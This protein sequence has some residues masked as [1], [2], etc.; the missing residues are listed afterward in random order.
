MRDTRAM[1]GSSAAIQ[2]HLAAAEDR[3]GAALRGCCSAA[4]PPP[5]AAESLRGDA[6]GKMLLCL[7]PQAQHSR[8]FR[9]GAAGGCCSVARRPPPPLA[10]LSPECPGV[11]AAGA[12]CCGWCP[13]PES[14]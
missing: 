8:Q 1:A 6:A 3:L 10:Q 13:L 9:T 4:R 7:A 2:S 11:S 14:A 5:G 12:R